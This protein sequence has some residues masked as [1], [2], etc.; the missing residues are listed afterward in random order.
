M[1]EIL[2]AYKFTAEKY[3]ED[4]GSVTSVSYTHLILKL[5]DAEEEKGWFHYDDKQGFVAATPEGECWTNLF[6]KMEPLS[7]KKKM[8]DKFPEYLTMYRKDW[9]EPVSYTHLC[10]V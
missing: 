8:K 7:K 9:F 6:H 2:N 1:E 5:F 4:D 10:L 3:I